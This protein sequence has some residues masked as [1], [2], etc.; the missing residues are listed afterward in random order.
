[1]DQSSSSE[2]VC[3]LHDRMLQFLSWPRKATI[4]VLTAEVEKVF[5]E[6]KLIFVDCDG[7]LKLIGEARVSIDACTYR[8]STLSKRFNSGQGAQSLA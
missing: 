3:D 5:L 7:L 4:G 8:R 2:V 6:L 1:M